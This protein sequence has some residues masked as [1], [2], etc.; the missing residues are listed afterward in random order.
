MRKYFY[1]TN[2]LQRTFL[3][4][5]FML[6]SNLLQKKDFEKLT[7]SFGTTFAKCPSFFDRLAYSLAENEYK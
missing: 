4:M 1:Y 2:I 7:L 5:T 6:L 3:L